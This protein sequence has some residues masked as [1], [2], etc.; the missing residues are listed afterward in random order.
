[1]VGGVVVGVDI[2]VDDGLEPWGF[3]DEQR[4][5][6]SL[7]HL[8][9]QQSA[10]NNNEE[11]GIFGIDGHCPQ[12]SAD[13]ANGKHLANSTVIGRWYL[14]SS[15]KPPSAYPPNFTL[16]LTIQ[17][18]YNLVCL[19]FLSSTPPCPPLNYHSSEMLSLGLLMFELRQ[20]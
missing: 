5:P 17:A 7:H 4:N 9:T 19:I 3:A 14:R 15:L 12:P 6:R 8:T 20:R 10:D 16:L 18:S 2:D 11:G 1:M 13:T